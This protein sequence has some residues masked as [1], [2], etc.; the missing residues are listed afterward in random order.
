[1]AISLGSLR[2]KPG[3]LR[4]FLWQDEI[5]ADDGAEKA[6]KDCGTEDFHVHSG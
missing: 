5:G 2:F 3:S 6:D 1:M 4:A